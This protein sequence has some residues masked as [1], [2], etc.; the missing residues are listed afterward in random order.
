MSH[1]AP[2]LRPQDFGIGQLFWRIHEA[3]IVGDA[4]SGR[5]V[6]W[7][8][9]AEALFGYSADEAVGRPIS[10]L[11]PAHRLGEERMILGRV[12]RGERVD[13]YETERVTKSG[14]MLTVS[15]TVSPIRD[16]DGTAVGAAVI[17][18]DIT[19]LQRSLMLAS[20]LQEVTSLLSRELE[21]ERIIDLV[22]R[23]LTDALGAQAG[24][25]GLLANEMI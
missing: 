9:A 21:G 15:L 6:L 3:V 11:I 10:I 12:L 1:A 4:G 24:A 19:L 13:H 7:N 14:R 22:L 25:V 20:M 8:P 17:A 18:R 16:A 5:I 23:Q 2:A